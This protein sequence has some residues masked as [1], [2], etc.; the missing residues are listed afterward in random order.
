M[1]DG[2]KTCWELM[3]CGREIGG[4]NEQALGECIASKEELGHSCWSIAG[5]L[6]R[7]RV[8]GTFAEK[9]AN[10]VR[11]EVFR[12]YHRTLGSQGKRVKELYPEEQSKFE[13]VLI[14]EAST[15]PAT[16]R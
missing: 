9:E 5:T 8:Q 6:C 3:G 14:E 16:T 2:L 7:G 12:L 4:R 11:C 13:R 1:S 15:P 10:C